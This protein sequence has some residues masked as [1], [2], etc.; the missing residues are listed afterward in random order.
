[1]VTGPKNALDAFLEAAG[2][3]LRE[4]VRS[5]DG[6]LPPLV[7]GIRTLMLKDVDR[8]DGAGQRRLRRWFEERRNTDVQVISLTSTALFSLVS[9]NAFDAELYY[10][11]NT[12]F[13][14]VQSI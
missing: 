5:A 11:L 1:M 9:E 12:I 4:P 2:P 8:L 7:D 13:L 10:R 3:E 14:E 6:T